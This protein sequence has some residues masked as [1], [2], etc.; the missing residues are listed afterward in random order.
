M[1]SRWRKSR[2]SL[3][4]RK[5]QYLLPCSALRE[6]SVGTMSDDSTT[7]KKRRVSSEYQLPESIA[8]EI[9]E[10]ITIEEEG[11]PQ[12]TTYKVITEVRAFPWQYFPFAS[13]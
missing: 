13:H 11:K 2:L 10:P 3:A 6:V 8:I 5:T 7:R 1:K 4:G 12:Y 9:A